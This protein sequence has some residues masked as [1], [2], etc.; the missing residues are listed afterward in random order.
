MEIP[1]I[2]R[3]MKCFLLVCIN[4]IFQSIL[5]MD[6]TERIFKLVCDILFF[7]LVLFIVSPI[8][9]LSV[10]LIVAFAIGHTINWISNGHIFSLLKTFGCI[11]TSEEQF[12]TF[13]Q[14][15]S[16][17]AK[18]ETSILAVACYGSISRGT[19]KKT[20]DL[21]VRLIRKSGFINGVRSC[22]F[23]L[24]LRSRAFLAAFPL[25]GYVLDDTRGLM[26]M[27]SDEKPVIVHDPSSVLK[28]WYGY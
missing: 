18:Q 19:L 24:L 22:I 4:W 25:D 28:N 8:T 16:R 27:R 12:E 6:R 3:I 1:Y 17:L 7:S 10:A 13:I 20:S 9:D 15:L 23:M 2:P 21:D 5:Y 14:Q 11:D 26:K